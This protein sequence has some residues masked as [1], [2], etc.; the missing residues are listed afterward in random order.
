[1]QQDV[2]QSMHSDLRVRC[3]WSSCS[4][5]LENQFSSFCYFEKFICWEAVCIG[6]AEKAGLEKWVGWRSKLSLTRINC[7]FPCSYQERRKVWTFWK[8]LYFNW[9]IVLNIPLSA[10]LVFRRENIWNGKCWQGSCICQMRFWL[11]ECAVALEIGCS[12]SA[13][14][15][16]LNSSILFGKTGCILM[17]VEGSCPF[18]VAFL[19]NA[20]F[21]YL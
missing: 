7:P 8:C 11:M 20:F 16:L 10:S 17:K 12:S 13:F 5:N 15:L 21:Y 19:F 6:A 1:M 14:L 3:S 2:W 9:N 18:A 4:D